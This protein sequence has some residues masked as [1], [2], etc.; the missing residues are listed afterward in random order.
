MAEH[1]MVNG[2]IVKGGNGTKSDEHG[3]WPTDQEALSLMATGLSNKEIARVRGVSTQAI[4]NSTSRI[5][6]TLHIET[7][8]KRVKAVLWALRNGYPR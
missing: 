7:G 4:K 8:E 5:Y 2:H 1:I 6:E 3:L